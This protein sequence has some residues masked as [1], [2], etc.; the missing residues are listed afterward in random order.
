[1]SEEPTLNDNEA[2]VTR[3]VR[4]VCPNGKPM[5]V[6]AEY[7]DDRGIDIDTLNVFP[8]FDDKVGERV[9]LD[10]EIRYLAALGLAEVLDKFAEDNEQNEQ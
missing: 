2:N 8:L 6:Q 5:I 9:P 3:I 4:A 7:C 10:D 1:M